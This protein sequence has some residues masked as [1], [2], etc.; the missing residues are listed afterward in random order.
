LRKQ[1]LQHL[2]EKGTDDCK[3]FIRLFRHSDVIAPRIHAIMTAAG[4]ECIVDPRI[5]RFGGVAQ[6]SH[7]GQTVIVAEKISSDFLATCCH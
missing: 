3:I 2:E 1:I 5:C 4:I 6:T 7:C